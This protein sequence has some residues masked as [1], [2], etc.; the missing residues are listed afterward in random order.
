[1]KRLLAN[2]HIIRRIPRDVELRAMH[3]RIVERRVLRERVKAGLLGISL[4]VGL[5][6]LAYCVVQLA[7]R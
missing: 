2:Q 5:V 3:A 7:V 4:A 1:M 6:S